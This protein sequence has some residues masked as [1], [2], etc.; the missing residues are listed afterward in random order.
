V[1]V[2]YKKLNY[3]LTQ[4]ERI[5]LLHSIND[6]LELMN[7]NHLLEKM[8][9][10]ILFSPDAKRITKKT[11]YNFYSEKQFKKRLD[12]ELLIENININN[13]RNNSEVDDENG[14]DEIIDFLIRKGQNHKKQIKQK[15]FPK[16]FYDNEI[17]EYLCAYQKTIIDYQE[18][19]KILKN[20]NFSKN[21]NELKDLL[22]QYGLNIKNF[23][24]SNIK[25]YIQLQKCIGKHIKFMRDDML[26]LKDKIKGTIYFKDVLPDDGKVNY[27]M[28]NFTNQKHIMALLKYPNVPLTH[29]VGALVWDLNNLIK[30]CKFNEDDLEI[31]KL[32]R[33]DDLTLEDIAKKVGNTHKKYVLE[34]LQKIANRIIKKYCEHYQDWLYLNYLRGNYK[35]CSKC[36]EIKL[37]QYFRKNNNTKDK[38]SSWCKKCENLSKNT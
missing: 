8:A 16:D 32:Y 14:F 27:D 33:Y 5:E 25:T 19:L 35:K 29:E 24:G 1:N 21:K 11:K 30:E 23:S 38:L 31:L 36:S 6:D 37:I 3:V 15:I 4:K 28:F 10:Y 12:K 34:K 20:Y 9:D 18:K 17:G 22:I 13:S 2:Y 26:Q 7:E